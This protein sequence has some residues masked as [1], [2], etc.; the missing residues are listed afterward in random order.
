MKRRRQR[1][2]RLAVGRRRRPPRRGRALLVATTLALALALALVIVRHWPRAP[3]LQGV[4]WSTAIY[5]RNGELLRLT[6]A[7]DGNYRL[8]VRLEDVEPRAIEAVL[9]HEDRHFLSH[10]GVN[11]WSM[12]R[13]AFRTF[14]I[15]DR[16]VGGSTITMQ[17]ARRLYFID[18]RRIPGKLQQVLR[19]LQLEA[20]YG[21]R[22]LLEAWLNL[23]PCGGNVEGFGAASLVYF[24][25]PARELTR[26]QAQ[27]LALVPQ[28]PLRRRP[29]SERALPF[30]APHQTTA[31]L[32]AATTTRVVATLDARTQRMLERSVAD[33]VARQRRIGVTN[34]AALL[35]DIRD[36]SVRASVGS[37]AFGDASIGGQVDGTRARRSP[38]STLKPFIYALAFDQGLVHPMSVLK[39]TPQAFG[40]QS[41]ENFD[42]EF[43][44]PLPAQEALVR[45]RN[46]PAVALGVQLAQ[47]RFH[48]F[49][50]D[51]GIAQLADERALGIAIYLGGA[52]VTMREL[53]TL[54]AALANG[55]ELRPLRDTLDAPAPVARPAPAS[56]LPT[57]PPSAR[58]RLF[59][60]G[61]SFMTLEALATN[62]R[63][64]R[65][66][67]GAAVPAAGAGP[68]YWKTGTS[69]GFRDAWSAGVFDHYVLVVWIGNFDGRP[70]PAF[71]GVQMAA[72]LFFE[73][74]DAVRARDRGGG[75]A[76]GRAIHHGA[77]ELDDR[78]ASMLRPPATVA[79]VEVC[80][81]SGDLP[82]EWCPRT[83]PTWY[84]PGTSP[85]RVSTL[86]RRVEVD[87]RTGSIACADTPA[88]FRRAEVDEFWSSDMLELFARAGLPR[89]KPPALDPRCAADAADQPQGRP[90]GILSPLEGVTYLL[91][92]TPAAAVSLRAFAD[93][94][95]TDLYWFADGAFIGRAP[96]AGP[97]DWRPA[98]AG[99]Y[100]L[101]VVDAAGRSASRRVDVAMADARG[102]VW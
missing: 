36:M 32:A 25:R 67:D 18:S 73:I 15:R 54:Y 35:V 77:G 48:E 60:E 57:A 24:R 55:G 81:D 6:L 75:G 40:A 85:I 43:A 70:N 11:P 44:G 96:G 68:V 20:L 91:A 61:A 74:V 66:S 30:L 9:M 41:P 29:R 42:G 78:P 90:P 17:L 8:P 46:V 80:A 51:A 65:A 21:K 53:A 37:A 4:G 2:L 82:N 12:A 58:R 50:R 97:L 19:A 14:A 87:V 34:A 1:D 10:W 101:R 13:G 39:D 79:R 71:V 64:G 26:A 28:S 76:G 92:S 7:P 86:H 31:L 49:L 27:A 69:N 62:P 93:A 63:P 95:S 94:D 16:R 56:A 88:A 83:V 45:S 47:P 102:D 84:M 72:P 23:A 5:D 100:L 33:Y 52:E 3:L 98:V 99:R 89:R 59:S 22:E 38:G